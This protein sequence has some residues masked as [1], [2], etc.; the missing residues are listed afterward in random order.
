M[1]LQ[2]F[3]EDVRWNLKEDIGHEE[4][5]QSSVVLVSGKVEVLDQAEDACVCNVRT[6]EKGEQVEDA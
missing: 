2:A 5:G 6:I 1:R 4:N 3:E